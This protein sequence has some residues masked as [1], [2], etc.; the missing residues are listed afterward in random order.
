MAETWTTADYALIISLCSLFLAL[1]SFIWNIWSKFIFPKPRIRVR[2]EVVH[3][4]LASSIIVTESAPGTFPGDWQAH[5]LSYP[6]IQI[7]ATNFG[8]G[9]VRLQAAIAA[10]SRRFASTAETEGMLNPYNDYPNDLESAGPFSG[11]LPRDL[12]VGEVFSAYFPIAEHWFTEEKLMK[13][14]FLDS[15]GRRHY[16]TSRDHR[17]LRQLVYHHTRA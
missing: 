1:A 6:S 16:S 11:G 3:C 9:K 5:H 12:E 7:S 2:V 14:G 17:S 10:K 15:F 8:P 13:F 4:D